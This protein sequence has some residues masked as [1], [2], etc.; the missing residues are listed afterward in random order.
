M[1]VYSK[2]GSHYLLLP[3]IFKFLFFMCECFICMY[4]PR[5]CSACR[6]KEILWD[7]LELEVTE[8]CGSPCGFW[9]LN[10]HSLQDQSQPLQAEPSLQLLLLFF[11]KKNMPIHFI[12]VY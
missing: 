4:A 9:E 11:C 8:R 5:A 12:H 2:A 7:L 1:N 3:L 6:G 10:P